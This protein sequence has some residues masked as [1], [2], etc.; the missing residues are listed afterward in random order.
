[1]YIHILLIIIIIILF[2]I[3]L[4]IKKSE[5]NTTRNLE[6]KNVVSSFIKALKQLRH[7]IVVK[8]FDIYK[9][10]RLLKKYQRRI[11]KS[12]DDV[13]TI[14]NERIKLEK[15]LLLCQRCWQFIED[16][17]H[18]PSWYVNIKNDDGTPYWKSKAI[19][20][21]ELILRKFSSSTLK[22]LISDSEKFS[23][24]DEIIEFCFKLGGNKYCFYVN[25]ELRYRDNISY[26]SNSGEL[27]LYYPVFVFE[28]N[29]H[30][31]FK[32]NLFYE[33]GEYGN[34]FGYY[35]LETFKPGL[36]AKFLLNKIVEVRKEEEQHKKESRKKTAKD[37]QKEKNDN[38]L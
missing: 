24:D 36:W 4:H 35:N 17:E 3:L 31:V 34:Y 20:P 5:Q 38:F 1:M 10:E 2:F 33:G 6:Y 32:S 13:E 7:E 8:L 28:N 12:K 15:D 19:K 9:F 23:S 22:K 16:I 25:R 26:S 30:L 37:V 18:Y 29:E 21:N 11:D 14:D 27:I